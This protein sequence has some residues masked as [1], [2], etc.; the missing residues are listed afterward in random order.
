MKR[1]SDKLPLPRLGAFPAKAA[2]A[3]GSASSGSAKIG[4]YSGLLVFGAVK[5]RGFAVA[6]RVLGWGLGFVVKRCWDGFWVRARPRA[7][8]HFPAPLSFECFH[9]QA[10]QPISMHPKAPAGRRVCD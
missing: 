8:L 7:F 9:R 1:K 4:L 5:G 10:L 2:R 6:F 3:G